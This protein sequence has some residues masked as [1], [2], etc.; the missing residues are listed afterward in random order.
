MRVHLF[1]S[2]GNVIDGP[3]DL[4]DGDDVLSLGLAVHSHYALVENTTRLNRE[5]GVED[6]DEPFLTIRPE[7]EP[8]PRLDTLANLRA[9]RP[10]AEGR[11]P[12]SNP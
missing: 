4:N 9:A 6:A 12:R 5:I 10:D 11:M 1:D 7:V 3:F 8:S 2:D